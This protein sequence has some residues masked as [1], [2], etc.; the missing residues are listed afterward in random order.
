MSKG[1]INNKDNIRQEVKLRVEKEK[2]EFDDQKK[3][4]NKITIDRDK[5]CTHCGDPGVT[6]SGLCL[7][8]VGSASMDSIPDIRRH[9][10]ERVKEEESLNLE[11][12]AQSF[13]KNIYFVGTKDGCLYRRK[14]SKKEP[15]PIRLANFTPKILQKIIYDDGTDESKQEMRLIIS[16]VLCGK[17]DLPQIEVPIEKYSNLN[18]ISPWLPYAQVEPGNTTREHILAY[19][20]KNL[21]TDFKIT[22]YFAQTG[23]R[24][25]NN[26]WLF[27]NGN[28]AVGADQSDDIKIKLDTETS[29]Y[30]FPIPP[31]S[32]SQEEVAEF[33][34]K[35]IEGLQVSLTFL[36]IG[37]KEVTF[38]LFAS[39]WLAPLCSILDRPVNFSYF[40]AGPSRTRKTTA[41]LAVLSHYGK[42]DTHARLAN[43]TSTPASLE[44]QAFRAADVPFVIDDWSPS[45]SAKQAEMK[46]NLVDQTIR[47]FANRSSRGRANPDMTQKDSKPPRGLLIITSELLP[48]I[49]SIITRVV[50]LEFNNDT[51]NLEEL[52][53][54]QNRASIL[55]YG[56]H[57]YLLWLRNNMNDIK[58]SFHDRFPVIREKAM[59]AGC[60]PRIGEHISFQMFSLETAA[61]FF[62]SRN[63]I[64]EQA[65]D[66][67]IKEA[68]D[69][70]INLSKRQE[71]QVKEED[72]VEIW[73]DIIITLLVQGE[74]RLEAYPGSSCSRIGNGEII[75]WHNSREI[76]ML[77]AAAWGVVKAYYRKTNSH[78]P[79]TSKT[80]FF[81]MLR[82]RKIVQMGPDR[83]TTIK[84]TIEG[85]SLRVLKIIEQ[86]IVEKCTGIS[87]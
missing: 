35:E 9:V 23:W 60:D 6:E 85:R 64:D 50:T 81:S 44:N 29:K 12:Y 16:G 39:V 83:K 11:E 54:F 58:K 21:S 37:K 84:A 18:W 82:N 24:F 17:K 71:A 57:A 63:I 74:A 53:T 19:A 31:P 48:S 59:Q 73:L 52:T 33:S 66:M 45:V 80:A 36:N 61:T 72:P 7:K 34:K 5:N 15:I 32:T 78:F 69:I 40:L 42:F 70:F 1:Q 8:C 20:L 87:S 38:P 56:M 3:D 13:D 55:P 10:Q 26:K 62:M 49:E 22:I 2:Q 77:P 30:S 65:A 43:F 79:I 68:W 75:G 67:L 28:G 86:S 25:I 14:H 27:L 47:N 51:M 41:A 76:F 4:K 46:A